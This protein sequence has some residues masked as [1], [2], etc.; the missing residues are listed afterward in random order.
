MGDRRVGG[1]GLTLSVISRHDMIYILGQFGRSVF[2]HFFLSLLFP[3]HPMSLKSRHFL[4]LLEI[5]GP[6][7]ELHFVHRLHLLQF[8]SAQ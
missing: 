1:G 2:T 5:P 4:V 7:L 8:S 3:G 6:H